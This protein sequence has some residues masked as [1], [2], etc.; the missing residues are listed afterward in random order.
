MSVPPWG[1]LKRPPD[2]PDARKTLGV[3]GFRAVNK[4][5]LRA[6]LAAAA[7]REEVSA[8]VRAHLE[9]LLNF[10]AGSTLSSP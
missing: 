2:W 9:M 8:I 6:V 7:N 5:R 1:A 4:G 10:A 3:Y